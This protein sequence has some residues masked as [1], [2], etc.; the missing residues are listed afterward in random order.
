[1]CCSSGKLPPI[2][3]PSEPLCSLLKGKTAQSKDFVKH[4]RLFNNMFAMT[5]FK[6]NFVLN[7]GWTRSKAKCTTMLDLFIQP[8]L[9]TAN[10]SRFTSCEKMSKCKHDWICLAVL[11]A[12]TLSS[13]P[14]PATQAGQR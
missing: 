11:L 10:I 9:K 4:I 3:K 1:M 14:S 5:S 13:S 7:N 8:M 2:L 12:E 6:S